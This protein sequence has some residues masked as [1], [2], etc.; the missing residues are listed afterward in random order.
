MITKQQLYDRSMKL[1]STRAQILV[2]CN[3]LTNTSAL[4]YSH[5][6]NAS[7]RQFD[8]TYANITYKEELENP[9]QE[10]LVLDQIQKLISTYGDIYGSFREADPVSAADAEFCAFEV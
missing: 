4:R 5:F 1:N 7:P 8:C 2:L 6:V 9:N 3:S 10:L